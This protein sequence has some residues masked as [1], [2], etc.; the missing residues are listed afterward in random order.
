M[1]NIEEKMYITKEV[2]AILVAYANEIIVKKFLLELSFYKPNKVHKKKAKNITELLITMSYYNGDIPGEEQIEVIGIV[3]K[4]LE[5]LNK[6]EIMSLYFLV[7]NKRYFENLDEF[8]INGEQYNED[9]SLK[10]FSE[11][12]GRYLAERIYAPK[13]TNLNNEIHSYF[14][15]LAILFSTDIDMSLIDKYTTSQILEM[16]TLYTK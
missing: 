13:A 11:N 3:S 9:A 12:F 15:D 4:F 10:E 6:N 2:N 14:N 5:K 7:L 16:I 8:E 1:I